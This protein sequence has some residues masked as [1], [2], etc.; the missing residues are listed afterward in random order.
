MKFQQWLQ[1]V[2]VLRVP[3][4]PY[5]MAMELERRTRVQPWTVYLDENT[6]YGV[7]IEWYC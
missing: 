1:T 4:N 3:H 2:I 5:S 6:L 7:S